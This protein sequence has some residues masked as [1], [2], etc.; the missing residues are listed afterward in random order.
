MCVRGWVGRQGIG[1][2]ATPLCL[3]VLSLA[4][5]PRWLECCLE[6]RYLPPVFKTGSF[7]VAQ[8]NLDFTVVQVSL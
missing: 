4:L 8:A 5:E 3:L 6:E 1:V 7:S 2:W